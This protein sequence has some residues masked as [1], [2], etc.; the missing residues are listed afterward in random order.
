MF[1]LQNGSVAP[2]N[3]DDLG[4]TVCKFVFEYHP[5]A[6]LMTFN[7]NVL[8]L[9]LCQLQKFTEN[10]DKLKVKLDGACKGIHKL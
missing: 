7:R 2:Y 5:D 9:D 4:E 8:E 1:C 10:A 6:E 3:Q